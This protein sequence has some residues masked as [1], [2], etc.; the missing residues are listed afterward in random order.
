M[1]NRRVLLVFL[2]IALGSAVLLAACVATGPR[3]LHAEARDIVG[4]GECYPC[5]FHFQCFSSCPFGQGYYFDDCGTT[6]DS[7]STCALDRWLVPCGGGKCSSLHPAITP[8]K[9]CEEDPIIP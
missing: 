9:D 1:K 6:G 2:Q 3:V 4:K 8:F 5:R 7:S